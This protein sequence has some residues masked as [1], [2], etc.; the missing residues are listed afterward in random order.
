MKTTHS[1]AATLL[2]RAPLR[3][4]IVSA[5][6]AYGL[7]APAF[8]SAD[9]AE[10]NQRINQLEAQIKDMQTQIGNLRDES[11]RNNAASA[12]GES[13]PSRGGAQDEDTRLFS[14][15]EINYNRPVHNTDA[16]QADVRRVVLGYQHR[17][18]DKT[19]ALVELEYE[20][21]V[22]SADD[23][24]ESEV[25]QAYVEH[26]F[27]SVV[28]VKAGLFLI[29]MGLLNEH[30]EPTAYYGVERNFVESAIIPTT[31]REGGFNVIATLDNGLTLQGGV[32]TGFDLG[33][34]DGTATEGQESPL[35]S[36]HQEL[37][38]AKAKDGSLFA[39]I[40]WRGIPGLQVGA[41]IFGGP[42]GQDNPL[43][44]DAG[45]LIWDTHVRWTPGKWDLSALYAR[46]TISNTEAFNTSIIGNITLMPELFDG[47]YVQAAYRAWENDEYS[48]SPFARYETYNTG[49]RYAFIG[50]GVTPAALETNKV[51]TVGANIGIGKNVVVKIDGQRFRPDSNRDRFDLGIGWSF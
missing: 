13:A 7:L 41:S 39:A 6:A 18:D 50:A 25:E 45:V 31:W 28:S 24:G 4:A 33:K 29:P 48:V 43:L 30:H 40:D 3:L 46:G 22:T 49:A 9:D 42:A 17:F 35:A 34:W 11:A 51:A 32:S 27:N 20:H 2:R 38:L 44:G 47:A 19:K 1:S 10:L 16:A 12:N 8:A 36:V 21:A 37:A 23:P 5:L 15:G 26:A 14:Y